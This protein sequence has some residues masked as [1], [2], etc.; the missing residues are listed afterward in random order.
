MRTVSLATRST[1][2]GR[3]DYIAVGTTV[4]RA[5]DLAARGGVSASSW[6]NHDIFEINTGSLLQVYLFEVIKIVPDE[7][8]PERTHRL[9]L[10]TFE[11]TKSVV[12]NIC[13]INGHLV[14]SMG[15]KLYARAF[16]QDEVL[17]AV[18]FLDVGVHVTSLQSL[19]NFI[20]LGD[21]LQSVSLVAFQVSQLA[22][23]ALARGIMQMPNVGARLQEDPYKLVLLGRDYRPSRVS[24]ANFL[25]D[26]GKVA[27]V[28]GDLSGV[29]RMFEYDPSSEWRALVPIRL[30]GG[31]S[32]WIDMSLC[33]P[34][35]RHCV[36]CRTA[37]ALSNRVLRRG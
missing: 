28:V 18:G 36:S 31:V 29:V 3:K 27:F 1:A 10:M 8:R 14:M 24:S 9:K 33:V 32:H 22:F 37:L 4:Y 5:E 11:D 12:G 15:Q 19:K 21:A 23:E 6:G 16:E 25:V 7:S 13:D 2:T 34:A 30:V 26:N 20:L 17:V 35:C